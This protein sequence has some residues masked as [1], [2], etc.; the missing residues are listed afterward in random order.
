MS[1][2]PIQITLH[3][4][5]LRGCPQNSDR[6]GREPTIREEEKDFY[7]K[8]VIRRAKSSDEYW[9]FYAPWSEDVPNFHMK[10]CHHHAA[11]PGSEMRQI[12]TAY[13]K[14]PKLNPDEKIAE[15]REHVA[16]HYPELVEQCPFPS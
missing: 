10:F 11:N 5:Q 6:F 13:N 9:R 12:F 15:I 1:S 3:I 4:C 2:D 16:E 8:G 14:N 7:P